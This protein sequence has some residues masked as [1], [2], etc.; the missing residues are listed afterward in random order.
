[1]A[2]VA[3]STTGSA[4]SAARAVWSSSWARAIAAATGAVASV[5]GLS[6]LGRRGAPRGR[7]GAWPAARGHLSLDA[8]GVSPNIHALGYKI[9]EGL[10]GP[11]TARSG[12]LIR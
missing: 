10:S 7:Y 5:I 12:L 1:M 8:Q 2:R 6:F 9:K 11:V 3:V 4:A